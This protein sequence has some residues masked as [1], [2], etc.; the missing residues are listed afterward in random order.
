MKRSAV[1]VLAVAALA[2]AA[3]TVSSCSTPTQ[4]ELELM[5]YEYIQI[6]EE[7]RQ[8]LPADVVETVDAYNNKDYYKAAVGFADILKN[9]K[10]R[11]LHQ[12]AHYYLT[13]CLDRLGFYQA[14]M[15]EL[16]NIL[17][18]GPDQNLYFSAALTKLLALTKETKDESI[19]FNVLQTIDINQF[20]PKFRNELIYMRGKRLYYEGNYEGAQKEFMQVAEDSAFYAK[21]LYFIGIIQVIRKEYAQAKRTFDKIMALPETYSDFG[22]ASKVKEMSKLALGQLYYKAGFEAKRDK[23]AIIS[24]AIKYY[25]MVNRNDEDQW[26]EALFEKTWA[27]TLLDRYNTALGTILTLNSP[28]F[29]HQFVPEV[30][31]IEAIT[32]YRLCKWPE[33]RSTV[34]HFLET[35]EPMQKS[36]GEYL[37]Q[38]IKTSGAVVYD[39]L[40]VQYEHALNDEPSKLQLPILTAVM[41][42]DN[43][44]LNIYL[45]IKELTKELELLDSAP[46]EFRNNEYIL[47]FEKQS[48]KKLMNLK[49]KGGNRALASLDGIGKM[50]RSLLANA[51]A[52]DFELTDSERRHLE[53]IELF[54]MTQAEYRAER[55]KYE[56]EN[57]TAAVADDEQYWPFQGEFWK[58]ELGYYYYSVSDECVEGED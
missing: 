11:A 54:G 35:F 49:K 17:F 9:P 42:N 44:F 3:L 6:S 20:P 52:I 37:Q 32:W 2:L 14:A 25:D 43:K 18:R 53:K 51:N 40:L 24:K 47:R 48:R 5:R 21:S 36:V 29:A 31:L 38:N 50:L 23:Y 28:F 26:F 39:D 45:A 34:S 15:F 22:E 7:K 27:S 8:K 12:T 46:E 16:A 56:E 4:R 58:D 57:Y 33:A 55:A 41:N 1:I 10:Y 30:N 13:E 19:I